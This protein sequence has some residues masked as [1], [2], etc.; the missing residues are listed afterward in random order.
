MVEDQEAARRAHKANHALLHDV[1][2]S[3]VTGMAELGIRGDVIELV[4]N[5]VS[6]ARGG[7]AGTYNRSELLPERTAALE[8]WA[9]YVAGLIEGRPANVVPLQ[10]AGA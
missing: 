8:R 9:V 10:M 3:V 4:V 1:R 6:G 7:I 5:H 2:R